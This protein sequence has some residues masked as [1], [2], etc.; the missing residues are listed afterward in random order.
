[1]YK[2]DYGVF[3]GRFQPFHNGHLQVVEEALKQCQRLIIIIGSA[4]NTRS[5][6]NPFNEVERMEMIEAATD[7]YRDRIIFGFVEDSAYNDEEWMKDVTKEVTDIVFYTASTNRESLKPLITLVGHSKDHTSFY[8]KMF[9]QWASISVDNY[10]GI[11]STPIRNDFFTKGLISEELPLGV[12]DYLQDFR[13]SNEFLD[14]AIE[15]DFIARYKKP[16]A[17]LPY[18]PIFSTVD[19]VV[20]QSGHVLLI[21]RRA[22]P[23]KGLWALP[24][25]FLNPRERIADAIIREL[26]EE[27]KIK[28][29]DPV[30]R[31]STVTTQVFDAPNRSA[32]GRT[33]THAALIHLK[34]DTKLPKV[35]GA[36]DADKAVWV[37]LAEVKRNMLFE[38]HY[39]IIQTLLGYIKT[40]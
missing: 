38:D 26:R 23:G 20:V 40:Q 22:S 8:L 9:P 10:E 16:Y 28:V 11:S 1:M 30:L 3:I 14:I 4:R 25:G 33:I 19:A 27:T 15:Y 32:R 17:N 6:H 24:G 18:E 31:G 29:P 13:D 39:C 21:R 35:T 7:S 12:R 36:D 34:P 37:P 2:Y 5:T